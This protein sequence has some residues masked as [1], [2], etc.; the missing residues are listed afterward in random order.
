MCSLQGT[1]KVHCVL[2]H[3]LPFEQRHMPFEW[4]PGKSSASAYVD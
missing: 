4:Q 3:L 2:L 1:E